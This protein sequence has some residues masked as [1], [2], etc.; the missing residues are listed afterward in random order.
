M[1]RRPLTDYYLLRHYTPEQ[2]HTG[3]TRL[4]AA[5]HEA[6][7]AVA[8]I[9]YGI[10]IT[11][12]SAEDNGA[13]HGWVDTVAAIRNPRDAGNFTTMLLAGRE[14]ES[15]Y[16]LEPL[17]EG[18]DAKDLEAIETIWADATGWVEQRD[19]SFITV[20]DDLPNRIARL[21]RRAHRLV[22]QPIHRSRIAVVRAELIRRGMMTGAEI[23]RCLGIEARS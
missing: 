16:F 19:G 9:R 23:Y 11:T 4:I 1:S 20:K 21:R 7:H 18:S 6:G 22:R 15:L 14:A 3:I 2:E 8:T 12:A 10:H 5:A 17:P 13:D